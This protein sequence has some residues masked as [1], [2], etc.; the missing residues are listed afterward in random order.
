[1]KNNLYNSC[2]INYFPFYLNDDTD[3]FSERSL[4]P[5]LFIFHVTLF[6]S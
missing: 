4:T 1:M 2:Y 5:I 6:L 3:D